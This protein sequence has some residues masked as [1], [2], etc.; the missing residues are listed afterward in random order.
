MKH[1]VVR[2]GQPVELN[3][4]CGNISGLMNFYLEGCWGS[5]SFHAACP[6]AEDPRLPR[7]VAL[8]QP[9]PTDCHRNPQSFHTPL[10]QSREPESSES[11]RLRQLPSPWQVVV[12]LV[13]GSLESPWELWQLPA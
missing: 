1:T 5:Q 11:P 12:P 3:M 7:A 4:G 6:G 10:L 13:W 9:C 2:K 8:G